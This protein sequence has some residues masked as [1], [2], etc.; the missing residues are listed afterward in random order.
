MLIQTRLIS[1]RKRVQCVL[2]EY[3]N[4]SGNFIMRIGHVSEK[5]VQ[6]SHIW[7]RKRA[8]KVDSV[9]QHQVWRQQV[10]IDCWDSILDRCFRFEEVPQLLQCQ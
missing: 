5:R 1:S 4:T 2:V 10:K 6:S 3:I 8:W 9:F 7:R